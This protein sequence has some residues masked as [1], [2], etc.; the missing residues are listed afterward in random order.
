MYRDKFDLSSPTSSVSDH[1][2]LNKDRKKLRI[3][4]T[5]LRTIGLLGVQNK[6]EEL[7]SRQKR[8]FFVEAFHSVKLLGQALQCPCTS[9]YC[10]ILHDDG[11][12]LSLVCGW[13]WSGLKFIFYTKSA[14]PI[15]VETYRIKEF[16]QIK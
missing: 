1:R 3:D 13:K 10:A 14:Q 12:Q 7:F 6:M 15:E 2:L 11:P 4:P 16:R 9:D 8:N 5:D